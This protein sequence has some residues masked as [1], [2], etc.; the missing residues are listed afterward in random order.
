[1]DELALKPTE[2]ATLGYQRLLSIVEQTCN[3]PLQL[4]LDLQRFN[5]YAPAMH[6]RL[7]SSLDKVLALLAQQEGEQFKL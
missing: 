3:D 6:Q 2:I 1:L 7:K 5:P 4:F